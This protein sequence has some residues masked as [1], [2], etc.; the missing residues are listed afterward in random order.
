MSGC[1]KSVSKQPTQLINVAEIRQT[2]A[3]KPVPRKFQTFTNISTSHVISVITAGLLFFKL[4]E[5]IRLKLFSAKL[6]AIFD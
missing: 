2:N 1:T 6:P 5:I 4:I 3:R